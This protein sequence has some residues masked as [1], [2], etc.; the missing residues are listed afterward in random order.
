VRPIAG[1]P[2]LSAAFADRVGITSDQTVPTLSPK[3]REEEGLARRV[4]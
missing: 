2:P 4:I 3:E 1:A